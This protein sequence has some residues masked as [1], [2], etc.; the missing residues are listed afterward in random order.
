M[1]YNGRMMVFML[2]VLALVFVLL[3]LVAGVRPKRS[4]LTMFE[5]ERRSNAH[6]EAAVVALR[7]YARPADR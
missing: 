6:N 7:K 4:T 1:G 5:L 2:I 3:I